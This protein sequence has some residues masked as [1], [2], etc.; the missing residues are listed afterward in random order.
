M[1]FPIT[2]E[3]LTGIV[4]VGGFA[5]AATGIGFGIV[6]GPFLIRAFG[7]DAGLVLTCVFSL[8]SALVSLLP[9]KTRPSSPEL[10]ILSLSLPVGIVLGAAVSVALDAGLVLAMYGTLLIC[11]GAT[12][13]IQAAR[14]VRTKA[15]APPGKSLAILRAGGVAAGTCAYLFGAPGPVAAWALARGQLPVDA[16]KATLSLYFVIA[17]PVVALMLF[18]LGRFAQ[19]DPVQ[20]LAQSGVCI[21]GSLAGMWAGRRLSQRLARGAIAALVIFAGISL[22]TGP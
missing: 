7:P 13:L 9:V 4:F 18:V 15:V 19:P 3:I 17:Y 14:R 16:M 8:A 10:R 11:L 2:L 20:L 6:A 21:L 1:T 22:L 5:Q 12:L